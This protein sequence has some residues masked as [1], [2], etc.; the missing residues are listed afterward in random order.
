MASGSIFNWLTTRSTESTKTLVPMV[1]TRSVEGTFVRTYRAA[2][3][4]LD[5]NSISVVAALLLLSSWLVWLFLGRLTVY[6]VS[7]RARVEIATAGLPVHGEVSGVIVR[8]NLP[9]GGRV[10]L[11]DVLF[12]LDAR[13]FELERP[14]VEATV[15]ADQLVISGYERE[16]RAEEQVH[17]YLSDVSGKTANAAQAK[18]DQAR[19]DS[20]WLAREADTV[21][22]LEDAGLVSKLDALHVNREHD[23]VHATITTQTTQ[24]VLDVASAQVTVG[25]HEARLASLK[26]ELSQARAKLE[27]DRA[28]LAI[29]AFEIARRMLRAR[30]TGVVA[31]VAPCA[32]GMPVNP[33]DRL[34]VLVPDGSL[35]IVAYFAPALAIGRVH[36]GQQ[37]QIR[38]ENYPWTQFGTV[39][40]AVDAVGAEL[41]DGLVRVELVPGASNTAIAL[42]HGLTGQVEVATDA[43][44]PWH[45]ILRSTGQ[46]SEG[47]REAPSRETTPI[48]KQY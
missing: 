47:A 44:T 27:Y 2:A 46:S 42:T 10:T 24:S 16:I 37:A 7:E 48:A 39:D 21:S 38:L 11:G 9:L 34:G 18:V 40:A 1:A 15:Q 33:G 36:P 31:D 45:F 32:P 29:N 26:R 13:S 22:R 17:G 19:S 4:T 43:V 35:R 12:E 25:Q 28:E 5:G 41:R 30:A 6:S 8:C 20:A 3:R 14:K 23:A